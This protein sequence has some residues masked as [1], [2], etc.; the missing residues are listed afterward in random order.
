MKSYILFLLH[1]IVFTCTFNASAQSVEFKIERLTD[2]TYQVVMK[3]SVTWI[4]PDNNTLGLQVTLLAPTGSLQITNLT[5]VNGVWTVLP[6]VVAPTEN[7]TKDYF[8]IY[9]PSSTQLPYTAGVETPLFTFKRVG[10]CTG[11]VELINNATDPFMPPNSRSFNVGNYVATTGG[12]GSGNN[13]WTANFGSTATCPR[14][15]QIE[16]RLIPLSTGKY[17][18]SMIPKI[19]LSGA[20]ATTATQQVTIVTPNGF[21]ATNVTNL[22][23]GATYKQTSRYDAPT[24]N[25]SKDYLVFTLQNLGT[26]TL[27]YAA[28]VEVPLFTF[29]NTGAC[30]TGLVA[31]MNNTADPFKQPN[32]RAA[33]V[34]QQITT[35]GAGIDMP[36][37]LS[38]DN[39]AACAVVPKVCQIEYKLIPLSTGKYQVSMIPKV[40]WSGALA[41]TA[42]QQVTIVVP[43]GGFVASNVM[44]LVGGATYRQTSRFNAPTENTGKDYLVFTLQNLGTTTLS[45]AANVEVPLFTFTNTGSCGTGN[46]ELMNNA[47]D[48]YKTPN[49]GSSNVGQQLTTIGGGIDVPICLNTAY[50]APCTVVPAPSC[51]IE[52]K[53]IPLSTGKYQVSMIPKVNWSGTDATTAT[54]QVTIVVPTGGF[55]AANV[56]NLVGGATYKQTSRFNAP[57]ANTGKDYLVFT[58][59]NLGTTTLSYAANVEVLLFTFTNGGLCGTGLV[60]LM[61]NATDAYRIPNSASSNVGQQITTIGGGI[62]VPICLNTQY[63]AACAVTCPTPV[64]LP[65]TVT[66]N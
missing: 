6:T 55:V 53:L 26:T 5:D 12:G 37:C 20:L 1:V 4:A 22:V 61:N 25:T 18:V 51:Q 9:M 27:S 10:A 2:D 24:E 39:S 30:G 23:G 59:Q 64:C 60:E 31:L 17:Q 54:Q 3:P 44:N 19:N 15:C 36:I 35:I 16:Y 63:S 46:V 38:T 7:P 65:V 58:L 29:D 11:T 40:D 43:T 41:T 13:L 57:T 48:A 47:T 42:T 14:D 66:R 34:G 62:D 50:S 8:V 56:T 49:S 32:S 52:Y 28:G 21:V 45:Y 33:N